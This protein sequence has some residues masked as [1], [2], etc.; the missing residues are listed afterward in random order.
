MKK[1]LL[2]TVPLALLAL[3]MVLGGPALANTGASLSYTAYDVFGAGAIP[4]ASG[5]EGEMATF[6]VASH[7][8]VQVPTSFYWEEGGLY[9]YNYDAT[10]TFRYT[11]RAMDVALSGK[12]DHMELYVQVSVEPFI[13]ALPFTSYQ[14]TYTPLGGGE[15]GTFVVL[16]WFLGLDDLPYMTLYGGEYDGYKNVGDLERGHIT[17]IVQH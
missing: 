4:S 13:F 1:K 5:I 12:I 14:G 2:L 16:F 7:L 10:G 15:G 9:Y 11:D 8:Q 6:A 3:A 17:K